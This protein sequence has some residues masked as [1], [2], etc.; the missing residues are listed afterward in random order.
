MIPIVNPFQ[1]YM[2]VVFF[3]YGLAF[4]SLGFMIIIR[5]HHHV[6]FEELTSFLWWLAGFGFVHGGL[7]W[8]DLWRVVHGDSPGLAWVRPW[9]LSCS[10]LFLLEFGRRM[11]SA[12]VVE[13]SILRAQVL[14][15]T[16]IIALLVDVFL[17]EQSVPSLDIAARNLLGFPSAILSACGLVLYYQ[18]KI[19]PTIAT[20]D[21]Q[22]PEQV[23]DYSW[24]LKQASY[25]SAFGFLAYGLFGGLVVPRASG[26]PANW[27]NYDTFLAVV[28]LPVQLVRAGCAIIITLAMGGL[29]RIFHIEMISR[30]SQSQW[31]VEN[32]AKRLEELVAERTTALEASREYS[33][34]LLNSNAVGIYGTDLDGNITFVNP[35][36]CE[37]LGYP[38]E[39]LLGRHSHE[40]LH[41][42]YPKG[43]CYPV[44]DCPI[45]K[46]LTQGD[47]I[48]NDREFFWRA[49][50]E[51]MPITYASHPI[52]CEGRIVGS[53]VSFFDITAQIEA[54]QALEE[55]LLEAQRLARIKSDFLTSMSHEIR[56]PM[57]T[58][59]ALTEAMVRDPLVSSV[60]TG[61]A[62]MILAATKTLLGIISNILDVA[63]L[64][65]G[66]FSLEVVCFHL[67][68]ALTNA[69]QSIQ[70]RA[71]KKNL[72][73]HLEYD[74]A[75]P[76]RCLG[77]PIRLRQAILNLVG[78]AIKFTEKGGVTISVRGGKGPEMFHFSVSDT[79]V[80]MTPAQVAKVFEPFT[81]ADQST[82]RRFGGIGIG[83]TLSKRII[84]LLGGKI[85]VESQPDIGS[86]FHFIVRLPHATRTVDC[87]YEEIETIPPVGEPRI[88]VN[89]S[90]DELGRFNPET[91]RKLL[92]EL[93]SALDELTPDAVEPIMLT[94]AEHLDKTDLVSIQDYVDAFDFDG[95]K[96]KTQILVRKFS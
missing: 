85:W 2:D 93:L 79:G 90:L 10:F 89:S 81:Q 45:L 95:A 50:G 26:F 9:V 92:E 53:V 41:H 46:T 32:H 31:L 47:I 22:S 88:V 34:V 96:E 74:T 33:R 71:L 36:A 17:S 24:Y 43:T 52:R 57:N 37:M 30:L 49:S 40:T 86:T 65:S 54:E 44:K 72:T 21:P 83:A 55:A 5:I 94:L 51:G 60:T 67:P 28:G 87:L 76:I 27:L 91:I 64:E 56:T 35:A 38:A 69:I 48:H 16:L 15:P 39:Q 19:K 12:C 75:L 3:F 66:Q 14:Y 78:N 63:K 6:R 4:F 23:D 82:T 68:N 59:I 1:P 20:I 29:L 58:I 8:M 18:R 42:S 13:I 11:V 73:I 80:G 84:E 61:H 70:H 25:L 77:D 62:P 7:E